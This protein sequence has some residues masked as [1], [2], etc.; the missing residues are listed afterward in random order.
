MRNLRRSISVALATA[1]V[2]SAA[3]LAGCTAGGEPAAQTDPPASSTVSPAPSPSP[4][5]SAS[6]TAAA[7]ALSATDPNAPYDA[8]EAERWSQGVSDD[9]TALLGLDTAPTGIVVHLDAETSQSHRVTAASL[10]PGDYSFH[11]AC[12]G[13]GELSVALTS[14]GT[15]S[16]VITGP[17]TGQLTSGDFTAADGGTEFLFTASGDPIDAALYYSPSTG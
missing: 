11:L 1:A 17:C 5:A 15:A 4:T 8:D 9:V 3:L 14:G 7:S 10:A 13:G 16:P 6:P 2:G 12:R